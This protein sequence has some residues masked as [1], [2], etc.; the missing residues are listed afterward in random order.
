MQ[1]I[2]ISMKRS[3]EWTAREKKNIERVFE[4]SE[5]KFNG[6]EDELSI[7]SD[8][9]NQYENILNAEVQKNLQALKD[10]SEKF[11]GVLGN[12][13]KVEKGQEIVMKELEKIESLFGK[14]KEIYS[15]YTLG[16][17][18][19][20]ER[21]KD[22]CDSTKRHVQDTFDGLCCVKGTGDLIGELDK[23]ELEI[24]ICI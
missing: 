18:D 16:K 21:I 15:V 4:E 20:I 17:Y 14:G 8:Q 19:E 12:L 10:M 2:Y 11:A 13:E 1:A 6:F 22:F 24:V 3:E 5:R 9:F 23:V 7:W